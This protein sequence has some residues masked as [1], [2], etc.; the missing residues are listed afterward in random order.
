MTNNLDEPS[1]LLFYGQTGITASVGGGGGEFHTEKGTKKPVKACR[2]VREWPAIDQSRQR[3]LCLESGTQLEAQFCARLWR[4]LAVML[5]LRMPQN[6]M[7]AINS[8]ALN[9]DAGTFHY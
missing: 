4:R 1:S 3:A 6:S 8:K 9:P 5:G 2:M 7:S